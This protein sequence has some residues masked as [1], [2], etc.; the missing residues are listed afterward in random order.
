M[1]TFTAPVFDGSCLHVAYGEHGPVKD[2]LWTP[3]GHHSLQRSIPA[4]TWAGPFRGWG[5]APSTR[6]SASTALKAPPKNCHTAAAHRCL[7]RHQAYGRRAGPAE[8]KQLEKSIRFARL[9]CQVIKSWREKVVSLSYPSV[10]IA[11][12]SDIPKPRAST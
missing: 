5:V 7:R 6:Q 2:R 3:C 4:E 12:V 10:V 1:L 11:I 8:K 9:H